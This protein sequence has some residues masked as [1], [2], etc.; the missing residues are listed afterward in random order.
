[1][2]KQN[3]LRAVFYGAAL[4]FIGVQYGGNALIAHSDA[5]KT[6]EI[7]ATLQ[8]T[9]DALQKYAKSSFRILDPAHPTTRLFFKFSLLGDSTQDSLPKSGFNAEAIQRPWTGYGSIFDRMTGGIS[10]KLV[11]CIVVLSPQTITPKNMRDMIS[12]TGP[13]FVKNLPGTHADYLKITALH[14]LEHCRHTTEGAPRFVQEYK[15]DQRALDTYLKEGGSQDVARSW[16]YFRSNKALEYALFLETDV[17]SSNPYTMGPAL[18][19]QFLAKK[20]SGTDAEG[21]ADLQGA[22]LDAAYA[23]EKGA[24]KYIVPVSHLRRP[25]TLYYV[26]TRLLKDPASN[27]TPDMRRILELNKEAYEFFTRPPAPKK[28]VVPT[29]AVS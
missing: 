13:A 27:L 19:D 12:Y 16:I 4:G 14:E 24:E 26:T 17:N 23:V 2:K 10:G 18:Y 6:D 22:Y 29:P 8:T 1:M 3:F 9:K 11:P 21:L 28:V 20:N 7:A 25:E 15:S 5:E